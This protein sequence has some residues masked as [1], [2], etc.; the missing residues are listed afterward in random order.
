MT[1]KVIL[2]YTHNSLPIDME[3]FFQR[4]LLQHA[5]DVP[6]VS[7][8]PNARN[9]LS[10]SFAHT[11]IVATNLPAP[12]WANILRQMTIGLDRIVADFGNAIVYLAEH[13]VMYSPSYYDLVPMDN[14][15]IVKNLN[16]YMMNRQGFFGPHNAW[17]HSQ[18]IACA[19][20]LINCINEPCESLK[21]FKTQDGYKLVK[22]NSDHCCIDVRHGKNYTGY[23]EPS[24]KKYLHELPF[25][26]THADLANSIPSFVSS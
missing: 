7:V 19:Q 6:I 1:S 4:K 10:A 20:L 24:T 2:Y 17:I 21:R 22:A 15:T 8:M 18:T 5:G 3:N 12:S 23:R 25:W 16:L 9:Q 26:G 14:T 11:N 13:D